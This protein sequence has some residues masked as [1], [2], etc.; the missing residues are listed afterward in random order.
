MQGRG[1][2]SG[3]RDSDSDLSDSNTK[4]N[5]TLSSE[6]SSLG[7]RLLVNMRSILKEMGIFRTTHTMLNPPR[8]PPKANK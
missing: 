5:E 8:S 2:L 1:E 3:S 6:P 4:A 7:S